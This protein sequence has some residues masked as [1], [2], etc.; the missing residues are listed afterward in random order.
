MRRRLREAVFAAYGRKCLKCGSDYKMAIDHIIPVSCGGT[1]DTN[2]LQPLCGRC[3]SSKRAKTID[4]RQVAVPV[5][6]PEGDYLDNS[7]IT[8]RMF[9]IRLPITLYNRLVEIAESQDRSVSYI[10]RK[11]VEQCYPE[12]KTTTDRPDRTTDTKADYQTDRPQDT[13]EG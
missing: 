12:Q 6:I 5:V 11:C 7:Q 8:H 2:N 10:I 4:Y 9:P 1:N 13:K 3:N